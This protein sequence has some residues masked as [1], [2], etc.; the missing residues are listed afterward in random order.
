MSFDSEERVG[1]IFV[2]CCCCCCSGLLAFAV[3]AGVDY[4]QGA[5]HVEIVE[6]TSGI[7][8]TI[9]LDD[10]ISTT[11]REKYW[12]STTTT[13]TTRTTTTTT[14][15]EK[16][17]QSTTTA[18]SSGE[19]AAESESDGELLTV[20]TEIVFQRDATPNAFSYSCQWCVRKPKKSSEYEYP[21]TYDYQNPVDFNEIQ[22]TTTCTSYSRDDEIFVYK[23]TAE[24]LNFA[25]HVPP[26][27]YNFNF[28]NIRLPQVR[29]ECRFIFR[30]YSEWLNVTQG[31]SGGA[32]A[33][34]EVIHVLPVNSTPVL[35]YTYNTST[36]N[37]SDPTGRSRR[38]YDMFNISSTGLEGR[39]YVRVEDA[40]ENDGTQHTP[41][42][43]TSTVS[44]VTKTTTSIS[45][46]SSVTETSTTSESTIS[47]V[48]KTTR[49]VCDRVK[50]TTNWYWECACTGIEN[51][52]V[53]GISQEYRHINFKGVSITKLSG[54]CLALDTYSFTLSNDELSMSGNANGVPMELTR[55]AG[56]DCF[57]GSW[58]GQCTGYLSYSG[59]KHAFAL[60]D[61]TTT[62]TIQHE[63]TTMTT[64]TTTKKTTLLGDNSLVASQDYSVITRVKKH[65][66][67]NA[68][69]K[70][71]AVEPPQFSDFVKD[72]VTPSDTNDVYADPT[73]P[74]LTANTPGSIPYAI[75]TPEPI[76][77]EADDTTPDSDN[78]NNNNNHPYA[79]RTYQH[80]DPSKE[81]G[82]VV[83]SDGSTTNIIRQSQ[84]VNLVD[85]KDVYKS[86][87]SSNVVPFV[88]EWFLEMLREGTFTK[89]NNVGAKKIPFPLVPSKL[90]GKLKATLDLKRFSISGRVETETTVVN[91]QTMK[92][93]MFVLMHVVAEGE[94]SLEASVAVQF[95]FEHMLGS[96][97]TGLHFFKK[98]KAIKFLADLEISIPLRFTVDIA[99]GVEAKYNFSK[100]E[101]YRVGFEC[102]RGSLNDSPYCQQISTELYKELRR[103]KGVC[104]LLHFPAS[105]RPD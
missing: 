40:E 36:F 24:D 23:L 66:Y 89:F 101:T 72:M 76:E 20:G 9:Q 63:T 85:L 73:L 21:E 19:A 64:T 60:G 94:V 91:K 46:Q 55:S 34:N 18:P 51:T 79:G 3:I 6:D 86:F 104:M 54:S 83:N 28:N 48:T 14:T 68:T 11:L 12:Q 10:G 58:R 8:E 97:K 13:T 37:E 65:L 78:D 42:P 96:G 87:D 80:P 52:Q 93:S 17:W 41:D 33:L 88:P 29:A 15:R 70:V 16:W 44:T 47:S 90:S 56:E 26:Q 77:G 103:M 32:V 4:G 57:V 105:S 2:I 100:V 84:N 99:G 82:T 30:H 50:G 95:S 38:Y 25:N 61:I 71:Y 7:P 31:N 75:L 1:L 45:T 59:V 39:L 27:S 74:K 98:F 5:V 81:S 67:T 43:L 53:T 62:T 92:T 102:T 49:N 35:E 69:H 22:T